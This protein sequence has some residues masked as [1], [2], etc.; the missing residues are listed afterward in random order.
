MGRNSLD[1]VR[2][3]ALQANSWLSF[4][5]LRSGDERLEAVLGAP[6]ESATAAPLYVVHSSI[7][8]RYLM[9]VGAVM[10]IKRDVALAI[11]A[12]ASIAFYLEKVEFFAIP[13]RA[14][15]ANVFENSFVPGH[16]CRYRPIEIKALI[17]SHRHEHHSQS[18][19]SPG[20]LSSV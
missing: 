2:V 7:V 11:D 6:I 19:V 5:R 20:S 18:A 10:K 9:T 8:F 1:T 3:T 14:A 13:K 15:V 16:A 12:S 17:L 4:F